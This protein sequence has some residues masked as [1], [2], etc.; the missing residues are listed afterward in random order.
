MTEWVQ[1]CSRAAEM[2]C[3][4]RLCLHDE[5]VAAAAARRVRVFLLVHGAPHRRHEDVAR[6]FAVADQ[7]A[8][9]GVSAA[10]GDGTAGITRVQSVR[11]RCQHSSLG[12]LWLEASMA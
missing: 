7:A 3:A 11:I 10:A 9:W 4:Q 8:A 1:S 2:P 5:A 6:R 12:I